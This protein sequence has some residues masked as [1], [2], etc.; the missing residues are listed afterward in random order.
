MN[1]EWMGVNLRGTKTKDLRVF[2]KLKAT[3]FFNFTVKNLRKKN[4]FRYERRL[5]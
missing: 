5:Q 1:L 3:L 4:T 2:K